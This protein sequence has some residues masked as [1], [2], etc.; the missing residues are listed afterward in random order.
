MRPLLL[1]LAATEWRAW[2]FCI[3][4]VLPHSLAFVDPWH[5]A[6]LHH[7]KSGPRCLQYFTVRS[8]TETVFRSFRVYDRISHLDIISGKRLPQHLSARMRDSNESVIVHQV[9]SAKII[10]DPRTFAHVVGQT[11]SAGSS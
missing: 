3:S 8:D 4:R 2:L 5:E 9:P 11:H 1:H 6:T 7:E 10:L